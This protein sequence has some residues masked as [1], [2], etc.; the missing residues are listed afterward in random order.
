MIK[1]KLKIKLSGLNQNHFLQE[2][3]KHKIPIKNYIQKSRS[4]SSFVVSSANYKKMDSLGLFA[5][6]SVCVK[7]ISGINFWLLKL[8]QKIGFFA[9]IFACFLFVLFSNQ[10]ILKISIV[11]PNAQTKSEI[12]KFLNSNNIVVGTDWKKINLE[13]VEAKLFYSIKNLSNVSV[14]KNG[15]CIILFI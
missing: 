15:T 13:T 2:C 12:S 8:P 14:Q 3:L 7:P 4:Q 11:A 9:G 1:N 10:K 5:R 6:Y